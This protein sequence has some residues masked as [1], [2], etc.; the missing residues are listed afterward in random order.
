[1]LIL[2]IKCKH[3]GKTISP[4]DA[5][6]IIGE[7]PQVQNQRIIGKLMGHLQGKAEDEGKGIIGGPHAQALIEATLVAQNLHMALVLG[8]F[9]LSAEMEADR[10]Q[11]LKRVHEI[12][13]TVK[14]TDNELE[15]L[16]ASAFDH[17]DALDDEGTILNHA[18]NALRDLRDRYEGLGKYAPKPPAAAQPVQTVK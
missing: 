10:Q 1:M 9:E 16:A 15:L 7:S 8:G 11:V 5:A 13:R 18:E 6:K 3:C 17:P 2:P 14:M 12:T 4:P